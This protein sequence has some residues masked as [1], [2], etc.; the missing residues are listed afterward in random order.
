MNIRSYTYGESMP[1]FYLHRQQW[2]N[3]EKWKTYRL[4]SLPSNVFFSLPLLLLST[5]YIS[6]PNLNRQPWQKSGAIT[7]LGGLKILKNCLA[8]GFA[9]L[10]NSF[11][12]FWAEDYISNVS[13]IAGE[14]CCSQWVCP[15]VYLDCYVF[16]HR[17]SRPNR[18]GVMRRLSEFFSIVGK[19]IVSNT[20]RS[21][22]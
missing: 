22:K 2:I 9:R 14:I 21:R 5:T 15:P 18:T 1:D 8:I 10:P 19:L 7:R 20:S 11:A 12:A 13:K 3:Y 17:L 4:S 6:F 16:I